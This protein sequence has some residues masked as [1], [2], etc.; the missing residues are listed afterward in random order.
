MGAGIR[1]YPFVATMRAIL[2]GNDKFVV[3]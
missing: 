3:P 1:A 2:R